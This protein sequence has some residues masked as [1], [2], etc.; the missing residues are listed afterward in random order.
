MEGFA[1]PNDKKRAAPRGPCSGTVSWGAVA[2]YLVDPAPAR[3]PGVRLAPPPAGV[4]RS[5]PEEKG[6][7]SRPSS[8]LH[9]RTT[10]S[11]AVPW[12][13]WSP[14]ASAPAVWV[15]GGGSAVLLDWGDCPS[16]HDLANFPVGSAV[17]GGIFDGSPVG[18]L[19]RFRSGPGGFLPPHLPGSWPGSGGGGWRL[20]DVWASCL[21]GV[22]RA[23]RCPARRQPRTS[24]LRVTFGLGLPGRAGGG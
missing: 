5:C 10:W 16:F 20:L 8:G 18:S 11:P 6:S 7:R 23:R 15:R 3:C 9:S 14:L 19:E 1:S 13:G 21:Q 22:R 2:R 24:G 4:E 12:L 17:P